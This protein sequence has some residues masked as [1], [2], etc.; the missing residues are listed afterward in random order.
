MAIF[1]KDQVVGKGICVGCGACVALLGG[2]MCSNHVGNFP[3][4]SDSTKNNKYAKIAYLACPGIG[5]HYP[6]LYRSHYGGLPNNWLLGQVLKTRVGYS[7]NNNIREGGA[8]GGV[9]T[10]TLSFLLENNYKGILI[11]DDI[12]MN[13]AMRGVWSHIKS[14]DVIAYDATNIGHL[15]EGGSG[16]GVVFFDK[17]H[18]SI[19]IVQSILKDVS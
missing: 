2:K 18:Q 8:S 6:S 15:C 3:V 1:F 5:I 16:T 14:S 10:Q 11:L 12:H 19:D 7:T 4:F 9:I 17:S 13:N